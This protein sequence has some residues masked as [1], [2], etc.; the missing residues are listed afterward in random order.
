MSFLQP[1]YVVFVIVIAIPVLIHLFGKE[2]AKPVPFGAMELLRAAQQEVAQRNR[3]RRWLLMA[4]RALAIAAIPL[5][6]AQPFFMTAAN[7]P[8]L[9]S[10]VQSAVVI[11]DDSASMGDGE[12]SPLV[13]ARAA[14]QQLIDSLAPDSDV[15]LLL[16]SHDA[17]APDVLIKELSRD[18]ARIG[19]AIDAIKP[20]SRA[21]DLLQAVRRANQILEQAP[22]AKRVIYLV[23]DFQTG[24]LPETIGKSAAD[25]VPIPVGDRARKNHAI[26]ELSVE[27]APELGARAVRIAVEVASY[28][29]AARGV[30]LGLTIDGQPIAQTPLDIAPGARELRKFTHLFAPPEEGKADVHRVIAE[31]PRDGLPA[32]DRR[33]AVVVVERSVRVLLVDGD[34]RTQKREDELFYVETALRASGGFELATVTPEQLTADRLA[35]VD[36]AVLC[37][38]RAPS[39]E[40]LKPFLERG[41]GL[42]IAMGG[43]VD[44]DAYNQSLGAV[45]PQPIQAMRTVGRTRD[46][47]RDGE[48]VESGGALSAARIG[49]VERTHPVFAGATLGDLRLDEELRAAQFGR[50]ALL[51]P[52]AE[53][54]T[55]LIAFADQAPLLVERKIGKG[56]TMLFASTLDRDWND[57]VIQPLFLPLMQRAVLHLGRVAQNA[58]PSGVLVGQRIDLQLP[59]RATR[60]EVKPPEGAIEKVDIKG[61]LA[62]YGPATQVGFYEVSLAISDDRVKAKSELDFAVNLDP[63]ESDITRLGEEQLKK[64]LQQD[65]AS[66]AKPNDRRVELWHW[67]GA[68]LLALLVMESLLVRRK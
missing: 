68:A 3:I 61:S 19:A 33:F 64:I 43:N 27:P 57:L 55:V 14:A 66:V 65:G 9:V 51:R 42:L 13:A 18:R 38:V 36:V 6:L 62:T 46:A 53:P 26:T 39:A 40:L 59:E 37:N 8:A 45:L 21:G 5:A 34:A 16:G 52:T 7:G 41:G 50:F 25:I 29:D 63:R 10:G 17:D 31:L 15:A 4:V 56:V 49:R 20:S 12:G 58:G 47:R 22:R 35:A 48:V 23:S 11:V 2:R 67:L 30:L 1:L 54:A 44:P 32:D 24:S 60:I 28:G